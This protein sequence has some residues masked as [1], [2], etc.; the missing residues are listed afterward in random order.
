MTQ[1]SIGSTSTY[2]LFGSLNIFLVPQLVL[3]LYFLSAKLRTIL[4]RPNKYKEI[5][6]NFFYV[7]FPRNTLLFQTLSVNL[8]VNY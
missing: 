6:A 3:A 4:F 1:I 5:L 7:N 8:Q 2:L